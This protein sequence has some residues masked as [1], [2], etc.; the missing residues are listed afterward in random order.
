MLAGIL[1]KNGG[2][3]QYGYENVFFNFEISKWRSD[4]FLKNLKWRNNLISKMIF[5]KKFQDFII[6]HQLNEIFSFFEIL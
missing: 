1:I 3:I 4:F 5:F 6:A 2:L